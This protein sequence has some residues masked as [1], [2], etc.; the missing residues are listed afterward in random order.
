VGAVAESGT[1]CALDAAHSRDEMDRLGLN[2]R[3]IRNVMAVPL[4]IKGQVLGVLVVQN[5]QG[6]KLFD[7]NDLHIIQAIADQAAA[8][9]KS[10]SVYSQLA[11]AD[12][13]RQEMKIAADI[14]AQLLPSEVPRVRNLGISVFIRPAKEIGGDY[15]D[16]VPYDA[17]RTGI[18]IGDVSGKGLPAGMI[19]IIAD[20]LLSIIAKRTM[21]T[22]QVIRDITGEMFD[23]MKNGTFM[24]L[25]YL[26]WDGETRVL[27]Y[28][29]AGH[30]FILWLHR[31]SG[32][33]ECVK[34][35]G[36]A[37]GL[38]GDPEE[39]LE[40]NEF[41]TLPG[42]VI[43]L[44]SDGVTEALNSRLERFTLNSLIESVKRHS[45][46]RDQDKIRDGILEDVFKFVGGFE[47]YDDITLLVLLV[48]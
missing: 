22:R 33:V 21:S 29:G 2:E 47:Q 14:Q 31:H 27:R 34:A 46:I 10:F 39:Y 40:E 42:D 38:V 19:M 28:T 43:V 8:S 16:F 48:A 44:Y 20:S 1:P 37:L 3:A 26:I 41:Y 17:D 35:G 30:E 24:T 45:S 11:E 7:S 6:D 15:Y 32:E 5:R 18:V 13:I 25:N 4:S 36:I 23:K 12:R 9:I